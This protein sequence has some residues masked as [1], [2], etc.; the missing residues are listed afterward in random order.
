MS[1]AVQPRFVARTAEASDQDGFDLR[2]LRA[3]RR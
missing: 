1:D 2:A 3:A